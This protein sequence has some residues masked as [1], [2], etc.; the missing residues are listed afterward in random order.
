MCMHHMLHASLCY[1]I[2]T[3]SYELRGVAGVY[4]FLP[5]PLSYDV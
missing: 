5:Q 1:L 4:L 2:C 3:S